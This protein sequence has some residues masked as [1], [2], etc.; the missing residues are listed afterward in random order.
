MLLTPGARDLGRKPSTEII[1]F[2][3]HEERKG[4]VPFCDALDL[5]AADL[6][7]NNVTVTFLGSFGTISGDASPLYV[8]RRSKKW[9]FPLQFLPDLD[10]LAA[11]RYII[12]RQRSVV[13]VPSPFENSPYTVLEAAIVGRPLI[14]SSS[15][16]AK[17]LLDASQHQALTC[18][19]ERRSLADKLS[20]AIQK[21]L[22]AAHL[23]TQPEETVRKWLELHATHRATLSLRHHRAK[24]QLVGA[25]T[26]PKV[27]AAITHYERPVKLYDALMSLIMQTYPNL[28]IIVVDDG[29][30]TIDTLR[31]ID[32]LM[33]LM[34]RLKVRL[35]RQENQYLG[36]AR[37]CAIEN[38][39]SD[40]IIFLDDD[41][42]AFP[43]LVQTLVTVAETT[44]ADVVNCLNLF[45][46]EARRDQAHPFPDLFE[47]K[48]SYVPIGGPLSMAPL[49]NCFGAATALLRRASLKSVDGYSDRY[50]VGHEDFELYARMAQL[51]MRIEV[52]P[53]PLYLYE[54][55]HIS[56]VSATSRLRNWN[57]IVSAIDM[58]RNLEA[59]SDLI[60]LVAG[61][62]A[63]EHIRN[64][65]EYL[66]EISPQKDLLKRIAAEPQHTAQYAELLALYAV[67]TDSPAAEQAFRA[68]VRMRSGRGDETTT[69]L[70]RPVVDALTLQ[71][72]TQPGILVVSA[73]LDL[74][75]SRVSE[76]LAGFTLLWQREA[77]MDPLGH[78]RVLRALTEHSDLTPTHASRILQLLRRK[79]PGNG[80]LRPFIPLLFRLALHAEELQTAGGMVQTAITYDQESYLAANPDVAEAVTDGEY[81]SALDHYARLGQR[82]G[83]MGFES[84]YEIRQALRAQTGVDIP[85]TS[86]LQYI[87]SIQNGQDAGRRQPDGDGPRQRHPRSGANG[88]RNPSRRRSTS[89]ERP[90]STL[91]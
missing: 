59:W 73:L 88:Q 27:V 71:D 47:Q 15:G 29:S 3:R 9:R 28:E 42:V 67:A 58:G 17:E 83:R 14:T 23:T 31:L 85:I 60:S 68:L 43:N 46:P 80:D 87:L 44:Q 63:Q 52:C 56:M 48:V 36:A 16:G 91:T 79:P 37:N 86:L 57:R 45:M 18:K 81:T 35:L 65:A 6:A 38:S 21:G 8:S 50:G 10:R 4:I 33:P 66:A 30:R 54:V 78:I 22:P 32:R 26:A 72:Q 12:D 41:D 69:A 20:I 34:E 11:C 24:A 90:R 2:G 55:D 39:N 1:F 84:L 82:Q 70:P 5:I 13:V 7:A 40:Y 53:L 25:T 77:G 64:S 49:E 61:Q 74:S 89:V 62:R 76:A 19:I 51:G 75:F